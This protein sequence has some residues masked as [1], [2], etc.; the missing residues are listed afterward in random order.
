MHT[1]KPKR[2][3]DR[4]ADRGGRTRRAKGR[5]PRGQR[6]CAPVKPT[7]VPIK[8]SDDG[9][10]VVGASIEGLDV[11]VVTIDHDDVAFSAKSMVFEVRLNGARVHPEA[12]GR[13]AFAARALVERAYAAAF[14]AGPSSLH[15]VFGAGSAAFRAALL[16]EAERVHEGRLVENAIRAIND[17]GDLSASPYHY[18]VFASGLRVVLEAVGER[19]FTVGAGGTVRTD[20]REKARGAWLDVTGCI[21]REEASPFPQAFVRVEGARVIELL[22][23]DHD[24]DTWDVMVD[25]DEVA[26][27][28]GLETART[29]A[30]VL[31]GVTR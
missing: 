13:S 17:L 1:T 15:T 14:G 23:D 31:A 26:R 19:G 4:A 21:D 6:E 11:E 9:R 5:A 8:W 2:T 7:I 27:V 18:D 12:Y 24:V 28:S 20:W 25:G 30:L 22:A 29:V 3:T 16:A 10:R